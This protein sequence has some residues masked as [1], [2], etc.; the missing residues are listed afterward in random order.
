MYP[1]AER[2][3]A[4]GLDILVDGFGLDEADHEGVCV[5][6]IPSSEKGH[7]TKSSHDY[8]KQESCEEK[9]LS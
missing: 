4:R 9:G 6:E 2:V 8:S 5:Q 1:N 7:N 3:E